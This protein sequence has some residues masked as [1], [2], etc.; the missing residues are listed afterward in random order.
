MRTNGTLSLESVPARR[1]EYQSM[2]LL[3]DQIA[4]V[5]GAS[6]GMG[7]AMALDFARHGA[8]VCLVARRRNLL[9]SVAEEAALEGG[10]AHVCCADLTQDEDIRNVGATVEQRFGRADVLILCGGAIFHQP[11]EHATLEQFDLQYRSNLR[12]H[13]A[14]VQ[15]LLP[16]LRKQQGQVVFIN[17]S[18][19]MR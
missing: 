18:V 5:T 6:G 14:L 8:E 12:G 2:G 4:I 11:V 7:R 15:A 9:E 19:S 13:Y 1:P 16:S 3:Q 17:S 10:R